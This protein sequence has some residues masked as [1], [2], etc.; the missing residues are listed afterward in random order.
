LWCV[1]GMLE[2]ALMHLVFSGTIYGA[3]ALGKH[4]GLVLKV[5]RSWS[6]LI[7][8]GFLLL[9]GW[10]MSGPEKPLPEDYLPDDYGLKLLDWEARVESVSGLWLAAAVVYLWGLLRRPTCSEIEQME[11]RDVVA[12][13]NRQLDTRE[14]NPGPPGNKWP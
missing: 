13:L 1:G 8:G 12:S 10:A 5:R 2:S 9:A 7:I 6:V 11:V 14:P 4:A 3:Y